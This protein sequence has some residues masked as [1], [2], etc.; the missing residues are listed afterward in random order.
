MK[1]IR[2]TARRATVLVASTAAGLLALT[3]V[4]VADNVKNDVASDTGVGGKR[5]VTVDE[6][7][8]VEY[9]VQPT[10]GSCDAADGSPVT[11]TIEKPAAVEASVSSLVFTHCDVSQP[12][13]FSSGSAGN[14]SIT[15]TAQDVRGTYNTNPA[16][17]DLVVNAKTVVTPPPAPD[18]DS[19]GVADAS[20]NCP[21]IANTDQ[22]DADGDTL[23]DA[24]DNNS[25]A[26][27]VGTQAGAANGNEGTPGNPTAS[28]SFT[29]QD[30]NS[31]LTITQ[32]AGAGSITQTA[33]QLANGE[34]SWSHTTTDDG[35]GSVTVTASD[36]EHTD[37][38][39]TFTWT[40]A[41]VAPV[42]SRVDVTQSA[43]CS[44]NLNADFSDQGT[45]DTHSA[46]I[47]WGDSSS[48]AGAVAGYAPA[49]SSSVSGSHTYNAAGTYTAEVTVT[50]DDGGVG[51][52][53]A[54]SGFTTSNTP[55]QIM[56]PI[57][58][59]GSRSGFKIGSTIPV[60]I[61][62]TDC[63]ANVVNTLTP[64]VSLSK[65]DSSPDV[66]VNEVISTSAP[67]SGT[68]MRWSDTQYI[69][70]LSTKNSQFNAGAALTAGTYKV[71]VSH[72][73]FFAPV[74]ATFDLKK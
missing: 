35:S 46:S 13:T 29:D 64:R 50:D 14:Y 49:G 56:Q 27:A 71:S 12:V 72:S 3:G 4:A 65:V 2:S 18:A 58:S 57:N 9:H 1:T 61:T 48:S 42:V 45:D 70:N 10:G 30:G 38:T 32:T 24:C 68:T 43:A 28:G 54:P 33:G 22:A 44:V 62:V 15:H 23:G 11:L 60:K 41:N 31:S 34:F 55:S 52:G 66:A 51:S 6:G 21:N 17:F 63:G 39:Q 26:P 16:N 53:S 74:S 8:T 36:G 47:D 73:S 7:T 25:H 37:A 19:D 67:T 20:D 40:A 69:Y 5:T 59:S